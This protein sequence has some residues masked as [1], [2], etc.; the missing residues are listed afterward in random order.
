M[1]KQFV[2]YLILI[3]AQAMAQP[4]YRHWDVAFA[5][6]TSNYSGEIANQSTAHTVFSEMR[7]QMALELNFN[8]S[9]AATIGFEGVFGSWY[10][11]DLNHKNGYGRNYEANSNYSHIGLQTD[12]YFFSNKDWRIKPFLGFGLGYTFY[13]T[14]VG[15][16]EGSSSVPTQEQ[17]LNKDVA[18]AF[19]GNGGLMYYL[20]RDVSLSLEFWL[21]LYSN[22]EID[23]LVYSTLD[24]DKIG[25]VRL[26]AHIKLFEH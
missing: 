21:G 8:L 3:S 14:R 11:N 12:Y 6:G 17:A 2:F 25:S 7:L 22:D 20:N 5:I 13:K 15:P 10:A 24:A 1:K 19:I 9:K 4:F 23:N 18:F 16:Q 26:K